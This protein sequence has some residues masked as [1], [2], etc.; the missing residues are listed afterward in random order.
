MI[1]ERQ[2]ELASLYALDL[3]EGAERA[4]FERTLAGDPALQALVR[5]LREAAA[6]LAHAAPPAAPPPALKSRVTASIDRAAPEK[7]IG[8]PASLFRTL[9]PW[10]I[11]AGFAVT[12]A[13]LG[14]LYVASQ[15]EGEQLRT[16]FAL[17]ELELKATRQ[18][19]EAE[20]IIGRA[21]LA[22]LDVANLEIST[23]A[24]LLKDS[25]EAIAVAVWSPAKQE[26]VLAVEKM[27]PVAA[28]Q[29]LE[30]WVVENKENAQPVSAGV[31]QFAGGAARV[32][33]KPTA[34]VGAV[35][36]FAVSRERNDGARAH[37]KPAEVIKLGAT[38]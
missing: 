6:A 18:Q 5:D 34:P 17:T 36:A 32:V 20:R 4:E 31:L 37:A 11:A 29:A 21:Q 24:S 7:I 38:H 15:F 13:W 33:F 23:L 25:P 3:L 19:L 9:L 30:L 16:Q 12:A 2:E 10:G 35:K 14:R 1:D 27:P 8:P 28:N 22:Q 26:G